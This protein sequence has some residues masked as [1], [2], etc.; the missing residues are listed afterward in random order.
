MAPNERALKNHELLF[1]GYVSKVAQT[2]PELIE[3]FDNFAFDEVLRHGD[4]DIRTRLMVQ[5]AAVIACQAL[6][7]YRVLLGAALNVGVTPVE[8]KEIVY[9]AVSYVGIAKVIDI[10]HITNDVLTERGIKLPLAGQSTTTPESRM[11]RGL[12]VEK[13]IVGDAVVDKLYASSPADELHFQ[14]YL[15]GNCFGD[16]YTRTGV[17]IP[18]R[19]LLTFSMLAALGGCEAQIRGHVGA[20]QNV[21]NDRSKL[22][23]VVTQLLPY[24]GYPRSLN[25]LKAIDD[26]LPPSA[27]KPEGENHG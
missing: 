17:D 3:L 22:I 4:L 23:D 5:L 16:T 7:E 26:I 6:T 11:G 21:G 9:H 18:T 12:A 20:N 10:V 25:A 1:P 2:D 13:Q 27:N 24:I 19:E 14:H 8:A 15:S